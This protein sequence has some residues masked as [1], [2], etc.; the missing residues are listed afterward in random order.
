MKKFTVTDEIEV[1]NMTAPWRYVCIPYEPLK[2]LKTGGWGSIPVYI[3]IGKTRWKT[4]LFPMKK[5][6]YFAPIKK[7]VCRVEGLVVGQ[8]VTL[9]VEVI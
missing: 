4:S 5:E 6:K 1:F 7:A 3:T 2:G 9:L 8:K